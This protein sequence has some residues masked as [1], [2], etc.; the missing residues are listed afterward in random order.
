MSAASCEDR[1]HDL[2]MSLQDYE[3]DALPT[4][5]TRQ[6]IYSY[7]RMLGQS[8]ASACHRNLMKKGTPL[9]SAEVLEISATYTFAG[10]LVPI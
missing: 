6:S 7:K 9:D 3:T 5:L 10:Y 4:G 1:T 8:H 2:Q